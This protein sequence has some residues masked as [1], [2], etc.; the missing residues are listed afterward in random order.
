MKFIFYCD[1]SY[2]NMSHRLWYKIG[3]VIKETLIHKI[4]YGENILRRFID[5]Y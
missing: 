1:E 5:A 2:D 3:N 4:S